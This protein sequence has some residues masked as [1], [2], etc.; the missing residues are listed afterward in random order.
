M[1]T[2]WKDLIARI[3]NHQSKGMANEDEIVLADR[4]EQLEL[5][6]EEARRVTF[7]PA[8]LERMNVL[9]AEVE[10]FNAAKRAFYTPNA[11]LE[12]ELAAFKAELAEAKHEVD[13]RDSWC[14]RMQRS[15]NI[16]IEQN[17]ALRA[18][19]QERVKRI[20]D[21]IVSEVYGE[22]RAARNASGHFG[23]VKV[24]AQEPVG[25]ADAAALSSV[26]NDPHNDV[27]IGV[28]SVPVPGDIA[29]YAG[30][31]PKQTIKVKTSD[32]IGP[33]LDWAVAKC[34]EDAAYRLE[35]REFGH[36]GKRPFMRDISLSSAGGGWWPHYS[37]NWSQGGL[38]IDRERIQFYSELRTRY[39]AYIGRFEAESVGSTHLIA[40]M[41]CYVAFKLGIIVDVPKELQ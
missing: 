34:E 37:T 15:W 16:L 5:E 32:L 9:E 1:T 7:D 33:A 13:V 4:I 30:Q 8:V 18:Q 29:I 40:A 3:R 21:D 38:I 41:R 22:Q 14:E 2:E 39:R 28:R 36:D 6:L 24:Q 11:A 27:M 17:A 20:G 19:A 31:S 10:K 26:K 35:L 23:E 12:A 25:Y